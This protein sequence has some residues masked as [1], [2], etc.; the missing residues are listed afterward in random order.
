MSS[1]TLQ[2]L[3]NYLR[4]LK[5]NHG[6]DYTEPR[7]ISIFGRTYPAID[8]HIS[9]GSKGFMHM[10]ASIPFENGTNA[11]VESS[12]DES[13]LSHDIPSINYPGDSSRRPHYSTHGYLNLHRDHPGKSTFDVNEDSVAHTHFA[14]TSPHKTTQWYNGAYSE[15]NEQDL[16]P[17]AIHNKL[18]N[19][20]RGPLVGVAFD[21]DFHARGKPPRKMTN[22]E[23]AGWQKN[24]QDKSILGL[25]PESPSH[26]IKIIGLRPYVHKDYNLLTEQLRDHEG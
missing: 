22:E 2:N 3:N 14:W 17:G 6:I 21:Q 10:S 11:W 9:I 18:H 4:S 1:E 25:V 5:S 19:W 8:K 26:M 12:L 16:A 15:I 20:S 24:K 7:G 23:H 13:R